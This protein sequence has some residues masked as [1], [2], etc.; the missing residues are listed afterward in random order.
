VPLTQPV[1]LIVRSKVYL[2][3]LFRVVVKKNNVQWLNDN[4]KIH[5]SVERLFTRQGEF[6][7]TLLNQEGAFVDILRVVSSQH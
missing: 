6:N 7:D 1:F 5:Y 4:T 3:N 2:K